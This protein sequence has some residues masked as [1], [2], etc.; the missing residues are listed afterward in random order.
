[1]Q[2]ETLTYFHDDLPCQGFLAY[3]ES[4][5][6]KRPVI[7]IA[8]TFRGQGERS[9]KLAKELAGLGY[10]GFAIDIY[11]E[12]KYT[13]DREEA[14]Q[15]M[16]PFFIDRK[17]LQERMI[18]AAKAI[19]SHLKVDK[20]KIGAVGFCFGGLAVYELLRSEKPVAGAVSIHGIF[21][22]ELWGEKAKLVP[23]APDIEGALLILNGHD[24]P[25]VP[26]ED[27]ERVA[28]EMTKAGI[29]WQIHNYG[30]TVH[31][32]TNPEAADPEGGVCYSEKSTR[33]A[34]RSMQI[35]FSELFG[36]E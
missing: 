30:H 6:A 9:R 5:Q 36:G 20:T 35:F 21:A 33:R 23:I 31:G 7:L 18:A 1:M 8:H 2:T 17:L 11:G 15:W 29:D 16:A 27:L 12:G 13:E 14:A 26:V 28:T 32:F 25:L 10:L 3:D 22:S 4:S 24:D 34:M 19:E